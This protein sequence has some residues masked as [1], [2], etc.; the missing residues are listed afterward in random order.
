M[1]SRYLSLLIVALA[2]LFTAQGCYVHAGFNVGEQSAPSTEKVAVSAMPER[3]A[4]VRE[5]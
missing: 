2:V 1:N 4:M 3:T 5:T